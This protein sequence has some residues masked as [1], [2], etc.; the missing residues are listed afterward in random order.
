MAGISAVQGAVTVNGGGT[1]SFSAP[2]PG[3]VVGVIVTLALVGATHDGYAW[4]LSAPVGSASALS[5]TDVESPTFLPD[6]SSDG[7]L[8][9][10]RGL[11]SDGATEATYLLPLVVPQTALA[12]YPGP[13]ALPY[14]NPAA[15]ATPGIGQVLY[16]DWSK[17]GAIAAK[18]ASAVTR[19]VQV[20]RSGV[21]GSRPSTANLDTGFCY[22]DTTLGHAIWFDG[23]DWVDA[24]GNTV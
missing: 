11:D 23:T 1:A 21:T 13:V 9:V 12:D 14:L 2:Q 18:D 22:F 16:Q 15:V 5:A 4:S 7:W 24:E 6:T 19:Q 8:I 3:L 20:I 17:G 10:L